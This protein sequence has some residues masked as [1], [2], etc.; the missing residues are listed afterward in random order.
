MTPGV[1]KEGLLRCA[2]V[3]AEP[4]RALGVWGLGFG[5]WGLGFGVWGLGFRVSDVGF[6]VGSRR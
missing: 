3:C 4:G 6:R 5:V 1:A 2:C